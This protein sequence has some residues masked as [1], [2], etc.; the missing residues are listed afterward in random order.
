MFAGPLDWLRRPVFAA[1]SVPLHLLITAGPTREA[2]DPVRFLS[3]RSSGRM[4]FALAQAAAEAG[5]RVTLVAGPVSLPTPEGVT[6]ADVT[7][8][9]EMAEAVRERV[10]GTDVAIFAAAVADYRPVAVAAQKLKKSADRLVLELERTTD[11]L[12]SMRAPWGFRGV[13]VGFAAETE[14][15]LSHAV[16]KMR[17][18]GCDLLVANDVSRPGTGFD[19]ADNEVALCFPSGTIRPLARAP[20]LEIAREVV[21][22]AVSLHAERFPH[23]T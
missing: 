4:G 7:S 19:S 23:H 15:V 21:T 13:L 22:V 5:H 11:I 14:A 10:A 1:G 8:A 2:I 18:K 3:N 12:G 6:R 16:E 17:R 20:K 9:A